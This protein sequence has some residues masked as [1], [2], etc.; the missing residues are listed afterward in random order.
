MLALAVQLASQ[1]PMAIVVVEED[2]AMTAARAMVVQRPG[3]EVAQGFWRRRC[4]L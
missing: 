4:G 1:Y 2:E 3:M